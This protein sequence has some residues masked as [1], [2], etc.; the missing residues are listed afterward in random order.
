MTFVVY[1]TSEF[2]IWLRGIPDAEAQDAITARVVR[3]QAG[4]LGDWKTVGKKVAEARVDVGAGYRIYFT[5]RGLDVLLLVCGGDK[6]TQAGDIK[7]AESM[8]A[9]L[10]AVAKAATAKTPRKSPKKRD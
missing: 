2:K 3:M 8:V 4:L 9:Q 10:N 7:R 6:S 1:Q 5:K